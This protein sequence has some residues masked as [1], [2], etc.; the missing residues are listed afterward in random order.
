MFE[1]TLAGLL[2][3]HLAPYVE[4]LD[5]KQLDVGIWG[6]DIQVSCGR[7]CVWPGPPQTS[8]GS[9]NFGRQLANLAIKPDVLAA[10]GLPFAVVHGHVGCITIK[11]PWKQLFPTPK[12]PV[13]V[14]IADVHLVVAPS[15]AQRYDAAAAAKLAQAAAAK[16]IAAHEAARLAASDD[17]AEAAKKKSFSAKLVASIVNNLQLTVRNV[18]IRY[19]DPVTVPGH[20]F[21]AGVTIAALTAVTTDAAF[22]PAFLTGLPAL[23]CKLVD[24]QALALY[25]NTDTQPLAADASWCAMRCGLGCVWG[26]RE[27]CA[28][29]LLLF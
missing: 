17:P 13:V 23:V 6:G 3:E 21:A 26:Y 25:F 1:K 5:P 2:N 22:R 16:L 10:L 11:V 24:L 9:L 4:G 28:H 27:P 14:E 19:E 7:V 18:H 8:T 20:T 29:G 12:K 15:V